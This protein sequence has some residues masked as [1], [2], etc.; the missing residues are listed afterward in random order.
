MTIQHP[1]CF[2]RA[3]KGFLGCYWCRKF[4]RPF[5][6]LKHGLC[7]CRRNLS[8]N[9]GLSFCCWRWINHI[10]NVFYSVSSIES[11]ISISNWNQCNLFGQERADKVRTSQLLVPW[12][13]QTKGSRYTTLYLSNCFT[14]GNS[15][16]IGTSFPL[17]VTLCRR[18]FVTQLIHMNK[19][20]VCRA[21]QC[22]FV[23]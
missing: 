19:E 6:V 20:P 8:H 7:T 14:V 10:N 15:N 22:E 23:G 17:L 18:V 9:L 16:S 5:I 21:V 13:T 3:R 2:S 4:V 12:E 1:F 11:V